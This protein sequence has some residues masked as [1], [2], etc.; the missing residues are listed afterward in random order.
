VKAKSSPQKAIEWSDIKKKNYLLKEARL[1]W[2]QSIDTKHLC[3]YVK[4][5]GGLSKR[6]TFS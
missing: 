2:Y 4:I 1:S 5:E 6:G 3:V